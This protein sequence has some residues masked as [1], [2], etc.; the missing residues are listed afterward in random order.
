M[1]TE[2]IGDLGTFEIDEESLLIRSPGQFEGSP[3]Y[4]PHFWELYL[5]GFADRDD[6][7]VL[8]FNIVPEDKIRFP[9]LRRR[10]TVKLV[11]D[12]QGF[13]SEV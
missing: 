9:E 1:R 13:V 12:D 10:R 11:K 8:G 6:G 3:R 4:V 7:R 2:K 5:C